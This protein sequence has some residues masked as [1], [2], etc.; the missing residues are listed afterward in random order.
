MGGGRGTPVRCWESDSSKHLSGL[1]LQ[2]LCLLHLRLQLLPGH[3]HVSPGSGVA[4]TCSR[5]K[6]R[7]GTERG[8]RTPSGLH[9]FQ[10]AESISVLCCRVERV[11]PSTSS[12]CPVQARECCE[13]LMKGGSMGWY[14]RSQTGVTDSADPLIGVASSSRIARCCL[15][16]SADVLAFI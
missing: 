6:A 7:Q 2:P 5:G 10:S 15:L 14:T 3:L 9:T 4:G 16:G 12:P 1:V 11:T 13:A 8:A